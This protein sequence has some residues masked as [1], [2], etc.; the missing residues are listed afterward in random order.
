MWLLEKVGFSSAE[1]LEPPEGA[2]EQ[3]RY[4]KRVMVAARV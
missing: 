3:L 1:V 4:H 2:Y